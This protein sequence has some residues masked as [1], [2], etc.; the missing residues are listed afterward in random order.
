MRRTLLAFLACTLISANAGASGRIVD[1]V[2]T[3]ADPVTGERQ[4]FFPLGSWSSGAT[5][6]EIALL[7]MNTAFV[8]APNMPGRLAPARQF[9]RECD[10]VGVHVIQYLSFG[11][12]TASAGWPADAVRVAGS[13]A[14]EPNLLAWNV[15][16]DIYVPG[17]AAI[18]RTVDIL[19]EIDPAIPTVA[20]CEPKI[21]RTEE[22]A[23]TFGNYVDISMNYDYPLPDVEYPLPGNGFREHQTFFDE[24]RAVFGDPLWTWTQTYMWHWTGQALNAGPEGPGPYPEPEQ[25][26]LLFLSEINRGLRGLLCFSHRELLLQPHLSA[27]VALTFREIALF[28]DLLAA[29]AWTGHLPASRPDIDAAVFQRDGSAA[30]SVCL[31]GE[32]YHHWVDEAIAEDSWVDVPWSGADIPHAGLVA[33]PDVV[34]C[35]V[36]RRDPGTIRVTIPRLEVGGIVLL[37]PDADG[38]ESLRRST[39]RIADELRTLVVP[40]AF[41]RI[42]LVNQVV[43]QSGAFSLQRTDISREPL[44]AGRRCS[45]A[46]AEGRNDDGVREWRDALRLC[47]VAIDSVMNSVR[48]REPDLLRH[49]RQ[50]LRT[51]YGLN[52]IRGL[53][54]APAPGD[55]WRFVRTWNIAGPFPLNRDDAEPGE[56]APGLLRSFAPETCGDSCGEFDTVDGPDRW[57]YAEADMSGRLDFLPHFATTRDVV[58]YA[59]CAIVAPSEMDVTMGLGSN[60]G[61]RVILNGEPVFI[62]PAPVG[63]KARPR[64]DE[65][66]VHLN[67]GRNVLLVK[68]ANY[69]ANWRL[70]LSLRD[71]DRVLGIGPW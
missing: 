32:E 58:T 69:G 5:A 44:A 33:T 30:L 27:E 13:L 21:G 70:F 23:H 47:R 68:V 62:A 28:N 61:A 57:R 9:M 46:I 59:R 71:P 45:D 18:R 56:T 52:G 15:G 14:S 64:Q 17:L 10:S 38:I 25:T 50:H 34:E 54:H 43:W 53:A 65:F 26:R 39:A 49:E 41:S 42:Q 63:R 2:M 6:E 67:A 48:A 31:L 3:V 12:R 16:D 20:D 11:G 66:T 35:S 37:T 36:E 19:R 60:D 8:G 24:Q 29:G 55:P 7:G 4:P 1:G 40:A 51:P 22:G